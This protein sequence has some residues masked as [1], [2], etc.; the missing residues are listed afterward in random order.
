MPS[1]GGL[2]CART[3]L[4]GLGSFCVGLR[5]RDFLSPAGEE[6][7]R[8]NAFWISYGKHPGDTISKFITDQVRSSSRNPPGNIAHDQRHIV[9]ESIICRIREDWAASAD[10]SRLYRNGTITGVIQGSSE[11]TEFARPAT[12]AWE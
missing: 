8:S 10:A 7:E 1:W 3:A 12:H 11:F 9:C 5:K 4:S 6:N 2:R